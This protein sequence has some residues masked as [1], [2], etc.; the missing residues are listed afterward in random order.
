[1]K[2]CAAALFLP[3]NIEDWNLDSAC[4][5]RDGT[6]PTPLDATCS[7]MIFF[8]SIRHVT[9]QYR[10]IPSGWWWWLALPASSQ[11]TQ[12]ATENYSQAQRACPSGVPSLGSSPPKDPPT[13]SIKVSS[14]ASQHR[15]RKK[16]QT[17]RAFHSVLSSLLSSDNLPACVHQ[18]KKKCPVLPLVE[19]P[20]AAL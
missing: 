9:R 6:S 18:K 12:R 10:V 1:L 11:P 3:Q 19:R 8:F 2:F 4:R 15:R 16:S 20:R 13:G 17:P 5:D 7:R 14:P